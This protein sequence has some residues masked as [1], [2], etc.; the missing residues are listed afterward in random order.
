MIG[1]VNRADPAQLVSAVNDLR[2][3]AANTALP[4]PTEDVDT[5]RAQR[6]DLVHQLEDYVLPRLSSLDA[7][8]LCVVGGSTGAGKSTLVNSLVGEQVTRAGV[9][10]PTTRASVLVH[11]PADASWFADQRILPGLARL[12]GAETH[13]ED[14]GQLRLVASPHIPQGL[15]LLDAPDIDSVVEANRDLARQLLSAADLWLFVTTA[16]RYADAVPWSLLHQATERGTSVAV[17]LNRVPMDAMEEVRADLAT[18]LMQ[19]GLG[20]SPVFAVL[21]SSLGP[22]GSLPMSEIGRIRS[23]LN[24]LAAD[25]RARAI[26]IRRTLDG[27]LDSLD[28]RATAV[29]RAAQEQVVAAQALDEIAGDAFGRARDEV[30][31]GIA[32]GSLLRGE[33]LA[34]WQEFVGT[35]E[36]MRQLDEGVGRLRDRIASVLRG[37]GKAE[38][39]ADL[40]EALHVG[41]A[42][43][44]ASEAES[45]ALGA[46]RLWRGQP[47]GAQL[48]TKDPALVGLAPG[49]DERV[50]RLVR[51]WQGE[52]LQMV[53]AE[54][55]G[56]RTT[57]RMLAFGIN[58]LGVMLMLIAFSAT[59]GAL[60]G[61]EVGVA[62]GSAIVAQRVLEAV[63]GDQAVRSLAARARE[64]LLEQ[65]SGVYDTEVQR[66]RA[67]VAELGIDQAAPAALERAAA[68]VRAAR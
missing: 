53:R 68:A 47:G 11:N 55:G 58:G 42:S 16:T 14:P 3:A 62:G 36:W 44:I 51:D 1:R 45:A 12:T 49:F 9:L 39:A 65:V 37:R 52:V 6:A 4:L 23:W 40:G 48:L 20:Q 57:A 26:V 31:E 27:A 19:Q 15:A 13:E 35:G 56:R 67:A 38:P 59:G 28:R 32:D 17:V 21:E 34:R 33:V 8:L 66:R 60:A 29:G 41:V 5:A 63:F 46:A 10:R 24:S 50:A 54:A 43:L 2:S 61:A 25:S 22:G 30:A 64:Q 7:P 18:M